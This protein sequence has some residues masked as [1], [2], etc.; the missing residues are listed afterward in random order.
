MKALVL[1]LSRYLALLVTAISICQ[2]AGTRTI[3]VVDG[4]RLETLKPNE[5]GPRGTYLYLGDDASKKHA[6][7]LRA[8]AKSRCLM[9][10]RIGARKAARAV[11]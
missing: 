6:A 1:A 7:T 4:I 8:P 11:F 2:A 10:L 3:Q 9:F 5:A